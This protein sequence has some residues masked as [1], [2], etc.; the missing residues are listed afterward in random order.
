MNLFEIFGTVSVDTT[1]AENGLGDVDAA[2]NQASDSLD[3]LDNNAQ[4]VGSSFSKIGK[5]MSDFGGKMTASVSLPIVG[6]IA[7]SIAAT[8]DYRQE[9]GK[10]DTAFEMNG[11]SVEQG[12]QAYS[13]LFQIIGDE[14]ASTEAAQQLAGLTSSQ[15]E[16]SEWTNVAAGVYGT[17]GDAL[18]IEGLA[19]AAN[20]T[21]KTGAL[22]GGLAD[23]LVWAGESEEEFQA[24]LESLSSEQ[25]RASF[26][27]ST[28]NGLYAES[29]TVFKEN[30]ESLMEQRASQE[31][32]TAAIS[33]FAEAALP[34]ITQLT[35][36]VAGL[37]EKFGKLSESQQEFIIKAL[38]VVAAIGPLIMIFGTLASGIGAIISIGTKLAGSWALIQGAGTLLAS[39]LAATI[40]FL[41]SPAG[42]IIM[43]IAAV[44]AAGVLLYK[45]WDK[46]KAFGSKLADGLKASWG[47]IVSAA[48]SSFGVLTDIMF[49]PIRTAAKL[50]KGTI[51]EILSFFDIEFKFPDV[52]LPSWVTGNDNKRGK[53]PPK[54]TNRYF[55][56]GGFMESATEFARSSDTSFIGGESGGEGIVPLEGRHM[57]PMAD[58]IAKILSNKNHEDKG[59]VIKNE[60]NMPNM[61]IREESD[62]AK[63]A[64]ELERIISRKNRLRGAY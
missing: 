25:E 31:R 35:N 44:I 53:K 49:N 48:K 14:G 57:I 22:T 8:Q 51:D 47:Y 34:V 3:D 64:E 15:Q 58:Q 59:V 40:G 30:N 32:L 26:I 46:V 43:G 56:K 33:E 39:G 2:A 42:L 7:G 60:F 45:N 18:P 10:L 19:E 50:I 62:I 29:G 52:N 9:M 5:S 4:N 23:A 12:R 24:K 11:K 27:L 20:E 13:E 55:A 28:M 37:M 21:A 17:F 36:F 63:I 54:P 1:A 6:A 61:I 38:L 16:L 41:L